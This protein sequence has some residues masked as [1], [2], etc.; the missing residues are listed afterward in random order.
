MP[1]TYILKAKYTVPHI[2]ER[3]QATKCIQY[4]IHDTKSCELPKSDS[5]KPIQ[6]LKI[7]EKNL[8]RIFFLYRIINNKHT[9]LYNLPT[10]LSI[11]WY[12]GL[13][14]FTNW[15]LILFLATPRTIPYSYNSW[16]NSHVSANKKRVQQ[17]LCLGIEGKKSF[18]FHMDLC[19]YVSVCESCVY[20]KIE[21]CVVV[22]YGKFCTKVRG[23]STML[24]YSMTLTSFKFKF[25]LF[26]LP[27]A[28]LPPLSFI[29]C[30]F[31]HIVY[32]NE[33]IWIVSVELNSIC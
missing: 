28:H 30:A 4:N 23:S 11:Q 27:N 24:H 5:M 1:K 33:D 2:I 15:F 26:C 12:N 17:A 20:V 10:I 3:S 14:E 13:C 18:L 21:G 6:L 8:I 32:T 16:C 22:W 31:I 19:D 29:F 25:F 9:L 7:Y